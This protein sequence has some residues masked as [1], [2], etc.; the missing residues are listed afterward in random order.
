M[1]IFK[2]IIIVSVIFFQ[3]SLKAQWLDRK[4]LD[5]IFLIEKKDSLDFLPFGTAFALYNYT[6]SKYPIMV[7][8]AHVVLGQSELYLSQAIDSTVLAFC[9]KNKIDSLES[10]GIKWFI[11][12]NR[13][14]CKIDFRSYPIVVDRDLDI[15]VFAKPLA[16]FEMPSNIVGE[17]PTIKTSIIPSSLFSMR[18]DIN[19]GDE[20]YFIGFPLGIGTKNKI[21]PLVR[22]GSVAW[23]SESANY[24]FLDALSY[25]GNSGSPVYTKPTSDNGTNFIGMV[26]GHTSQRLKNVLTQPNKD[27]I[28][29]YPD[30]DVNY[31]LARVVFV[32]DIIKLAKRAELS[33]KNK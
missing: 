23:V 17:Y 15:C 25:G 3:L 11:S 10:G 16:V 13:L 9:K 31:G 20:V 7:T 32:D 2:N 5:N 28:E 21:E 4:Y 30:L 24:F 29:I 22:T 18:S 12:G 27:Q 8:C 26:T 33:T 14:R 1:N 19:L 6:N